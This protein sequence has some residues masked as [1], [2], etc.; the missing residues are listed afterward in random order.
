MWG[1]EVIQGRDFMNNYYMAIHTPWIKLRA[2]TT[3]NGG[4]I[5]RSETVIRWKGEF[6]CYCGMAR[7]QGRIMRNIAYRDQ[8]WIECYKV[9]QLITGD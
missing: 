7:S 6:S 1:T 8:L 4:V 3:C 9:M 5:A 2:G